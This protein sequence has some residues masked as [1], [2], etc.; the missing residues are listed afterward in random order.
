MKQRMSDWVL[1]VGLCIGVALLAC[2]CAANVRR[3]E[4]STRPLALDT[5]QLKMGQRIFMNKCQPCHP[6]GEGGVGLALNNKPLPA[7]L[8][9]FQVRHGL[10][11]M[12]AFG[13]EIISDEELDALAAYVVA[14]R[15]AD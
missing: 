1:P 12:P 11:A 8:I 2:G 9:K 5:P 4:P 6:G 3:G 13:P 10:G 15:Q 7:G 14:L